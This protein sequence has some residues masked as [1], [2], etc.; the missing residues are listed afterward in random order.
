[1]KGLLYLFGFFA[2]L[3]DDYHSHDCNYRNGNH[4]DGSNNSGIAVLVGRNGAGGLAAC[5]PGGRR[6]GGSG[7]AVGLICILRGCFRLLC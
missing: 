3:S 1:M 7:G 4:G 6:A 2:V 5:V